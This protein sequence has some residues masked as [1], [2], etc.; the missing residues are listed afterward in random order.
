MN[1]LDQN[2]ARGTG[3][4]FTFIVGDDGIICPNLDTGEFWEGGAKVGEDW[5]TRDNNGFIGIKEGNVVP[6]YQEF[7]VVS[8]GE[9][10][11]HVIVR[12]SSCWKGYTT[13]TSEEERKGEIEDFLLEGFSGG[14]EVISHTD[15]V[16]VTD[17]FTCGGCE[18]SPEIELV[19]VETS[20]D[21]I[22]KG[23]G[24]FSD[25]IVHEIGCP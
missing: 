1:L 22:I 6:R 4:T 9:L 7:V 16:E 19:V 15:H 17:L 14:D 24:S 10:N 8:D 13:V 21:Q 20:S 23:N 2:I 25:Q 18:S 5:D 3:H 12:K 11:S